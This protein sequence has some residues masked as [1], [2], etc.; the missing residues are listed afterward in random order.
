MQS[1]YHSCSE[2]SVCLLLVY[3]IATVFQ[4]YHGSDMMYEMRMKNPKPTLLPT[5]RIFN[6]QHHIDM[7]WEELAF[8]DAVSIHS[9]GMD[10]RTAKCY[11]NDWDSYPCPQGHIPSA[12]TSY[13]LQW[14]MCLSSWQ[15]CVKWMLEPTNN[16]RISQM[17]TLCNHVMLTRK[18]VCVCVGARVCGGC[19][20]V[21]VVGV[22]AASSEVRRSPY[23]AYRWVCII[24]A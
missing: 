9:G 17:H 6:L 23:R 10:R 5:Q 12:L 11:S 22:E 16:V 21:C 8:D 15:G 7:T 13:V 2:R 14:H 18:R 4:L 24:R 1:R 19:V 20:R 3:T